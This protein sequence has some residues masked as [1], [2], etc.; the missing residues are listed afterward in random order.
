MAGVATADPH[1]D[2]LPGSGPQC[3]L[4]LCRLRIPVQ[5]HEKGV[6]LPYAPDRA[7]DQSRE[8]D[9]FGM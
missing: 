2:R 4:D 5:I 9:S 1:A 3:P 6:F 7:R 8:V